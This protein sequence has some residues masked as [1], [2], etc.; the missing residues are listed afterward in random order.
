MRSKVCL[1]DPSLAYKKKWFNNWYR[2]HEEYKSFC[3]YASK[4]NEKGV[5]KAVIIAI[6]HY[7]ICICIQIS[8]SYFYIQLNVELNLKNLGKIYVFLRLSLEINVKTFDL[9]Y[10]FIL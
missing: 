9:D 7:K 4:V 10:C 3:C 2:D 6:F 8:F 5:F 1:S